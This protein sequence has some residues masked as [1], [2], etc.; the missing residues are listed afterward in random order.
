MSVTPPTFR[1][2]LGRFASGVCVITTRRNDGSRAGLTIS[3]F[4]SLSLEPPLVLFCI[5]KRSANLDAFITAN[6]FAVNILS[7]RHEVLSEGFAALTG[8]RFANV[9]GDTAL[10]GCFRIRGALVTLECQ[11]SSVYEAGDHHIVIGLVQN[12]HFGDA[13]DGP[14]LRYRGAY[15]A[16]P[17]AD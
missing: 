10:N 14:L 11:R 5:G 3:A 13:A 2:A 8:D 9:E 7:E 12:A 17:P 1:E 6:D 4:T 15:R 16:L